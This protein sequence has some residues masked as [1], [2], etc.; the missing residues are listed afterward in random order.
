[1]KKFATAMVVTATAV[2]LLVAGSP[3]WA[4]VIPALC[5]IKPGSFPTPINPSSNGVIPV[6]ICGTATFDVA[7]VDVTTLAFGPAG[8]APAH[9]N[10]GHVDDICGYNPDGLDDLI[11]HFR[12]QETGIAFGDIA[13]CLT[14][15]TLDGTPFEC[16]DVIHT[17]IGPGN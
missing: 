13:A 15:E 9:K 12:T 4:E 7:D 11:G 1:M 14:G 3:A 17:E 10:A 16:C 6:A 5:D 2:L 8:A